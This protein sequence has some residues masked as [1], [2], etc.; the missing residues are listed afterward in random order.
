MS[1]EEGDGESN[2]L[3]ALFIYFLCALF[4]TLAQWTSQDQI[5]SGKEKR[6]QNDKNDL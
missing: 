4:N 3:C 6:I 2:Q 1:L 5:Y